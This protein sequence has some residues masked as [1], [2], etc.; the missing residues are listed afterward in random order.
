MRTIIKFLFLV[1][2]PLSIFSSQN[3]SN[4]IA[5]YNLLVDFTFDDIMI[6]NQL[7]DGNT[8]GYIIGFGGGNASKTV[9]TT[10]S[11][12]TRTYIQQ[13]NKI[14][15]ICTQNLEDHCFS[16][17][18]EEGGRIN[19][20]SYQ[21]SNKSVPGEAHIYFTSDSGIREIKKYSQR[22]QVFTLSTVSMP[23]N[24]YVVYTFAPVQDLKIFGVW[25]ETNPYTF[26]KFLDSPTIKEIK[27]FEFGKLSSLLRGRGYE[28]DKYFNL[29]EKPPQENQI[30][31][32]D[33]KNNPIENSKKGFFTKGSAF[34]IS[35][36][37]YYVS[38]DHVTQDCQNI[39]LG[40]G[41]NKHKS[42]IVFS[43]KENDISIIKSKFKSLEVIPLS[44]KRPKLL[45][46]VYVAG[47]P[48]GDE[49][50]DTIKITKGVVSSL[51]GI[52]NDTSEIQIDAALQ[53]GNSGG[54]I[55]DKEGNLLG[56]ATYILNKEYFIKKY[57]SIPENSNFGIKTSSLINLI[58]ALD[59][60]IGVKPR[61]NNYRNTDML[62]ELL[63]GSTYK[64]LCSNNSNQ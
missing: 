43:D 37:G 26:C 55:V 31:D 22:G 47:F 35:V 34:S 15:K 5:H 12:Q 54:P 23:K 16:E 30:I 6:L 18:T 50:S 39:H 45:Q 2:F 59:I 11:E 19:D 33:R 10:P 27:N 60:D 4:G 62:G 17:Y 41:A 46:E 8:L 1:T 24:F 20:F 40:Q 38:N 49:Y 7:T 36:D 29:I 52:N 28:C 56:I 53:P 51:V 3:E 21:F 42:E 9:F 48:F 25:A 61:I 58:N 44:K 64:V 13:H 32:D 63:E 57:G 14:S